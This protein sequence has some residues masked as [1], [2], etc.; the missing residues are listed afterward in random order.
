MS[1]ARERIAESFNAY[2]ADWD[3]RIRPEDVVMGCR[4]TVVEQRSLRWP[5]PGWRVNYRVDPDDNGLPCLEFYATHRMTNDRHVRIGADG[6]G[7]HLEAISEIFVVDPQNP[8]SGDERNAA[9]ERE[10]RDCGLY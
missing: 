5:R 4:G 10:I 3:V 2:F 8:M 7:E 6:Q 9:I 1:S